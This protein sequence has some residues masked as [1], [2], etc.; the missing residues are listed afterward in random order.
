MAQENVVVDMVQSDFSKELINRNN[1][2]AHK[3]KAWE[4]DYAIV[5]LGS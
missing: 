1:M 4:P 5:N 3:I 2:L